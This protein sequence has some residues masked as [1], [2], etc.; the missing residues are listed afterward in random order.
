[1]Y[2]ELERDSATKAFV[3]QIR[4]LKL[5]VRTASAPQLG[6][7][8]RGT[9]TAGNARSQAL[10][11]GRYTATVTR[12]E[13]LASPTFEPGEDNVGNYGRYRLELRD[14][15]WTL[16]NLSIDYT[17]GG[18]YTVDADTIT[19]RPDTP[20]P[21]GEVFEYRWSLYRGALTLT[22]VRPSPTP[23]VVHPWIRV[24]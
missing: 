21:T 16:I 8:R 4:T 24:S 9:G 5:A 18:T 2:A 12:P 17:S 10:I 7:C 1:V 23:F 13:L 20:D 11:A 6:T 14:G 19:L 15:R 22:Q 3:R